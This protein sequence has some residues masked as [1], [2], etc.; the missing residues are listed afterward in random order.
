MK[1]C[2][3][4]V[5]V[6]MMVFS[7]ST[8][9]SR[10]FAQEID[11][12]DNEF[13][14]I[15]NYKMDIL[16][17][18]DEKKLIVAERVTFTNFYSEDLSNLVLHLYPD[19][20][21]STEGMPAIGG[22]YID[23]DKNNLQESMFGDIDILS[24]TMNNTKLDYSE[25]NQVLNISLEKPLK[26][27]EQISFTISFILDIPEGTH[28]LG[29]FENV[30]S[31]TNWYPIMSIY[32]E[33]EGSWDE[34]PYHPVGESNYSNVANYEMTLIVSKEMEVASTG[35]VINEKVLEDRKVLD[36][37]A[38]KVR[39]FVIMM[40]EDYEVV[41]TEVDGIRINSYYI[42]DSQSSSDEASKENAEI[43]L[44]VVSDTVKFFNETIGKYPYKELDITETYLSGG[45]MEYPQLIQ[46]GRY[47]YI[48][49]DYK[50]SNRVSFL[51]E[52]AVHEAIHQW[53][54]VAVGNNE[55]EESFMDESLTVFTTAYYFE[56]NFGKYHN[57][58]VTLKIRNRIYP[59]K[60]SPFNS[61][62][63]E[64]S[65]WGEYGSII[66]GRGP[67]VFEDLR[68]QVGEEKFLEI[69]RTYFDRYLFKNGSIEGF[70]DIVKEIGGE[71][72]VESIY[73]AI[74]TQE[75]FPEHLL[76]TREEEAEIRRQRE[77]EQFKYL[78]EQY[79]IVFASMYLKG[80]E[81]ETIYF[82]VPESMDTSEA[83]EDSYE[84]HMVENKDI[85][86]L[87]S[88][89]MEFQDVGIDYKILKPKEI[90]ESELTG[91]VILMG[92]INSNELLK[93]LNS[94]L[95]II[96]TS[97]GLIMDD[98]LIQS[99]ETHGAFILNNPYN[100]EN[101]MMV[102]FWDDINAID[103]IYQYSYIWHEPIQLKI[104]I[105]NTK[106][107]MGRY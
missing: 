67:I 11:E 23:K 105:E 28:R 43:I 65:D 26:P 49:K 38:E 75:Y 62:V 1:K 53:W 14:D 6:F 70:L 100:E 27:Q 66:Y 57:N 93:E 99:Q 34:N 31:L 61:P 59:S 92:N 51:I 33:K 79:G 50:S 73:E 19:A 13:K 96:K 29:Y 58:G 25:N 37:K 84:K 74:T 32:D 46:M 35:V 107:I 81:G 55:Y 78:E 77:I 17:D 2:V 7:F 87:Q 69:L 98:I 54:Y 16:F 86:L 42:L 39:D 71:E 106:T 68:S 64:F 8:Y 94:S 82:V 5:I 9:E 4:I 63:D 52:A 12:K 95:P 47:H 90:T 85:N 48:D 72:V 45:A 40:S 3:A 36:I 18:N 22:I 83:T 91:N 89:L 80:L 88:F 104:N 41:S 76:L 24:V 101:V 56:K 102:I 21:G 97:K 15:T 60:H 103:N 44:E 20:Y 30:V 10:S